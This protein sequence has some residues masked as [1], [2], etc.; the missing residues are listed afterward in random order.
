MLLVSLH[1]FRA[2]EQFNERD[3]GNETAGVCPKGHAAAFGAN[4]HG[5]A[6]NLNQEPVPQHHPRRHAHR[7]EEKAKEYECINSYPWIKN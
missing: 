2:N 1:I 4:A 5:A 7:G 6:D 3:A